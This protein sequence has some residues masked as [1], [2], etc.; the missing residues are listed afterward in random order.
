MASVATKVSRVL[1]YTYTARFWSSLFVVIRSPSENIRR[2]LLD[3]FSASPPDNDEQHH[4]R[5]NTRYDANR[6]NVHLLCSFKKLQ[7]FPMFRPSTIQPNSMSTQ[8]LR[9]ESDHRGPQD[10]HQESGENKEHQ[11]RHHFY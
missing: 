9:H 2:S 11:R 3:G 10:H 5:Q 1:L 7:P 6:G 4:H 8:K